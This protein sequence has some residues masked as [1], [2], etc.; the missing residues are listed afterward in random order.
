MRKCPGL[1]QSQKAE[2]NAII[3]QARDAVAALR[4]VSSK[5]YDFTE[6]HKTWLEDVV[7]A[8][9]GENS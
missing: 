8:I 2:I 5:M 7:D 4:N 9:T 1:V 3:A 6:T